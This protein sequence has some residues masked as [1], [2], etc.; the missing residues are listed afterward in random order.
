MTTF[1]ALLRGINVGG[2][3]K[4]AMADLRA[5]FAEAGGEDVTTYIQSGNVVFGHRARSPDKLG[6]ELEQRIEAMAGFTVAVVLRT[7]A[8]MAAVVSD[9]PFPDVEPTKVHVTFLSS[10]PPAGALDKVDAAAFA[11]EE[12]VLAGRHI[13]LHLP[14]GMA[15]TRLPQALDVFPTP[16]TTRNWRTVLKLVELAGA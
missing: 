1:I 7:A 13:Y 11:P 5:L 15:R 14:N 4:V 2:R 6:G 12:F 3:H 8:Q 9:N 16:V 10:D